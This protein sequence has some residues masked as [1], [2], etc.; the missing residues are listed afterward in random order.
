MKHKKPNVVIMSEHMCS[1]QRALANI[2]RDLIENNVKHFQNLS[3]LCLALVD[4]YL[5]NV[6]NLMKSITNNM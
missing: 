1:E 6:Q 4:V 5:F 2:F 3:S